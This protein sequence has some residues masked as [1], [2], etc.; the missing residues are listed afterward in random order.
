MMSKVFAICFLALAA[1]VL[2]FGTWSIVVITLAAGSNKQGFEPII[3]TAFPFHL[4][5]VSLTLGISGIL[6]LIGKRLWPRQAEHN[7]VASKG[8]V[9]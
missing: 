3:D 6:A 7:A 4:I 1:G 9:P 2:V 8:G 5:S